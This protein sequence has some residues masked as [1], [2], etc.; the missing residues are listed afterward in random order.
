MNVIHGFKILD[1]RVIN[2]SKSLTILGFRYQ[3]SFFYLLRWDEK[4]LINTYKYNGAKLGLFSLHS[5]FPGIEI[6]V[7]LR[8]TSLKRMAYSYK[9]TTRLGT[10]IQ[11]DTPAVSQ[12]QPISTPSWFSI[13][14]KCW[15]EKDLRDKFV[16]KVIL[17]Q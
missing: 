3:N 12:P 14:T 4:V 16:W 7:M 9:S 1:E 13:R 6:N 11:G 8:Y 5:D 2:G 10:S 15:L 17:N